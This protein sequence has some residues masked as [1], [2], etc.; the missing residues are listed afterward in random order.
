MF[1]A[2]FLGIQNSEKKKEIIA[3]H[4]PTIHKFI[5]RFLLWKHETYSGSLYSTQYATQYM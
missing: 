4:I 2:I 3:H 1:A 5:D